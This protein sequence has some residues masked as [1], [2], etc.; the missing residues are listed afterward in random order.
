MKLHASLAFPSVPFKL[1]N[2]SASQFQHPGFYLQSVRWICNLYPPQ[3]YRDQDG[4]NIERQ[5][6]R[7]TCLLIIDWAHLD[8]CFKQLVFKSEL[9]NFVEA[10]HPVI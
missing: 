8:S 9:G 3:G 10:S 7:V 2:T 5:T 6:V 1:D 4:Y